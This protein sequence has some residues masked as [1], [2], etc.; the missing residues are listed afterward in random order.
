MVAHETIV[1][2]T[3]T[4]AVISK[5]LLVLEVG[6]AVVTAATAGLVDIMLFSKK[7]KKKYKT[8]DAKN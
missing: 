4:R 5:Y 7:F 3:P 1:A 6:R 2:A 8:D